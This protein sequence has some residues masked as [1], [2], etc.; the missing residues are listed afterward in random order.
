MSSN[1]VEKI[2]KTVDMAVE[3]AL[4]HL[5]VTRD[6]ADVEIIDAGTKGI[7][8]LGSKPAKVRVSV[9][10]NP[11]QIAE[12]FIKEIGAAMGIVIDVKIKATDKQLDVVLV[13]DNIGILIGKRG[14][15]LDSL[16]YLVSLAVN[17]GT[18]P[19]LNVT[20]DTEGYR[21]KRKEALETLAKNIARRVRTTKKA[22]TL[23]PMST[24][25][26]RIIHATL[27]GDRSITTHS[28]GSDPFRN[29]V[30]APRR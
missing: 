1:F 15:T 11:E 30:V 19:F 20:V 29:I 28:E 12:D 27:Q 16:Q 18:A 5:G 4:K 22:V 3:A 10:H 21:Q 9:K 6:D 2:A 8:G 14:Q 24:F 17:K 13:G 7:L 25:E 26:R 23:E